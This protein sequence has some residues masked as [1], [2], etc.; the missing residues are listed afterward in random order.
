M[1]IATK[2]KAPGAKGSKPVN[3]TYITRSGIAP[4]RGPS[5]AVITR[6]SR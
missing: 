2:W 5:P 3:K 1:K 4:G 6:A